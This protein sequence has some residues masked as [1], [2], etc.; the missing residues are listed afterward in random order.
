[1]QLIRNLLDRLPGHGFWRR[2]HDALQKPLGGYEVD[3]AGGGPI[4]KG[5]TPLEALD[6]QPGEWVRIKPFSEIRK[7]LNR[8]G[9]NRGMRYDIEMQPFSGMVCRV[10]RRVTRIIDEPTGVMVEM[11]N[12][13]IILEGVYCTSR[14]SINRMFCPRRLP[15]FW[16]E[17]WLERAT[18]PLREVE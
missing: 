12:P 11:K 4:D 17:N 3:L 7:T 8:D 5:P 6:L 15:S 18:I 2:L 16:R 1:M 9:K 14:F 10:A 13:S